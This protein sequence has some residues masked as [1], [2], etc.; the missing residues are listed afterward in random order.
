MKKLFFWAVT[1]CCVF[2]MGGES[3]AA[4]ATISIP[5]FDNK[6]KIDRTVADSF[7]DMVSTAFVK[8][9][10]FNVVE[11]SSLGKVADE[12][13][14]GASGAVDQK[15]AAKIGKMQGSQ[16]VLIG[17]I[18]TFGTETSKTGA[19]G[20]SVSS[21]ETKVGVDIRLVNTTTGAIMMA[22]SITMTESDSGISGGASG[23]KHSRTL[24]QGPLADLARKVSNEIAKKSMFAIY[25]PK[26]LQVKSNSLIVNYGDAIMKVGQLYDVY[27]LGEAL[28]DPDTGESL[29][30]G[31]EFIGSVKIA[32]TTAKVSYAD[33]I[34][35]GS[36]IQKG[37]ILRPKQVEESSAPSIS[38]PW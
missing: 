4:K 26:I 22:E 38:V 11:R 27:I 18:T 2:L 10:K 15:T 7:V 20:I 19:F 14:F 33:I 36:G 30:S 34:E 28:I 35:P 21:S 24:K 29:G 9:R 17:S 13:M 12:Q 3:F 25:P 37:M 16:F 1:V 8:T 32:R 5:S 23:V 6:A 31:E